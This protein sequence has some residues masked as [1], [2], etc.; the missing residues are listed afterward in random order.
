MLEDDIREYLKGLVGVELDAR[1]RY[2]LRKNIEL[3][4][5]LEAKTPVTF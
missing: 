1:Q 4:R 2:N 3:L 5:E